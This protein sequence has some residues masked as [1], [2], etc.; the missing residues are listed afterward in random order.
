MPIPK[1]SKLEFERRWLAPKEFARQLNS[2][3]I[4]IEDKYLSCG[5]LRLRKMSGNVSP[6]YKLC[7]KYGSP[8]LANEPIVNIYLTEQEYLSLKNLVGY[9][10]RKK[11]Y[12]YTDG[13]SEFSV[14]VFEGTHKDIILAE[15]ETHDIESL[16][17]IPSPSFA[18]KEV[19][20]DI[21]FT[22]GHLA[23]LAVEL[24]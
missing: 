14:D 11:R 10:I 3:Y 16:E 22:G 13:P 7:K 5:R 4:V 19:T 9:E 1:Y 12:K 21:H 20:G 2:P 17:S 15:I 23:K 18:T 8:A 6:V 24:A